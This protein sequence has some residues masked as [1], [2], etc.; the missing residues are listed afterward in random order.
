MRKYGNLV[1]DLARLL[2][3]KKPEG[4]DNPMLEIEVR[5][6]KEMAQ[7]V[8]HVMKRVNAQTENEIC[9]IAYVMGKQLSWSEKM[10]EKQIEA[11]ELVREDEREANR[12]S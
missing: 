12:S 10:K 8:T 4:A 3:D 5:Q 2:Q 1:P 7:T 11:A 6:S 9:L